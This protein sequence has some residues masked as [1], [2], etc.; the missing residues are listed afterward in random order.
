M[1][2]TVYTKHA[3]VQ[4][5]A[6]TKALDKYGLRY[7]SVDLTADDAARDRV[8]ELGH[9]QAPVV[10]VEYPNQA[11]ESW[12]GFRPGRIKELST[13]PTAQTLI[14]AAAPAELGSGIDTGQTES[15]PPPSATAPD[16]ECAYTEVSA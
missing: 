3:C 6:T 12:S 5:H 14:A 10:V 11:D 7:D 1:K 2:I 4:C 16:V 13:P 15:A 9:R 8:M